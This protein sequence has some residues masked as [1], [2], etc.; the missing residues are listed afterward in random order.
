MYFSR[1]TKKFYMLQLFPGV[2]DSVY[3]CKSCRI[4][5]FFPFLHVFIF[6]RRFGA[7]HHKLATLAHARSS[8]HVPTFATFPPLP[9]FRRPLQTFYGNKK[10]R[11]FRIVLYSNWQRP[12]FPGSFPPSIIGAKELNFCVRDGN[13]CD[14]LAIVTRFFMHLQ[15]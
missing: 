8:G 11:L 7:W 6:Y 9:G 3:Q 13:R 2:C 12:T 15:N 14:L 5:V 1:H 10:R 4:S